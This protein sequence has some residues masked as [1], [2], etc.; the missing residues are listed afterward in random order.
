MGY[1]TD[2]TH[3]ST[4]DRGLMIDQYGGFVEK[5][6]AKA[7]VMRQYVRLYPLRG[8]DTLVNRRM[9]KTTLQKIGDAEAG[10]H[11]TGIVTRFGKVKLTVDTIV[12][13]RDNRALLNE[14]QTDINARAELAED[15]GKT[16]GKF[17]DESFLIQC[18]KGALAAAPVD[19]N[20]IGAGKHV[21]LAAAGDELD[22]TKFEAA[23]RGIVTRFAEDD[24]DREELLVWVRPTQFD[25][26]ATHDKLTSIEFSGANG[27]FASARVARVAGARI[28]ETARIPKAA[29]TGHILS[30]AENGNAYDVSADEAKCKAVIMHPR[31]LLAAESIPLTSDVWYDKGTFQWYIDS[32]L[33][34]GVTVNRP[35]LCGAVFSY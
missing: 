31:S 19:V 13:A 20:S 35:D 1:P 10:Q 23:I 16:I 11:I 25:I 33:A 4:F 30:N 12:L 14:F 22:P 7:S 29:I 28:V 27:D 6:I 2:N 32:Y 21:S 3:L 26:L 18:I 9:G 5:Q 8:T 15:H 34:Y 17:F 24:V